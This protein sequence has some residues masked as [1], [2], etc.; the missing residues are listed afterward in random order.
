M[1][2]GRYV[3]GTRGRRFESSRSDHKT[4]QNQWLNSHPISG[5][6]EQIGINRDGFGQ[7]GTKSP[8]RIP[9]DVRLT[10]SGPPTQA[11]RHG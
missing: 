11:P 1:D 10:F 3:W 7:S 2:I 6:E 8:D 9:T 4:S 5:A